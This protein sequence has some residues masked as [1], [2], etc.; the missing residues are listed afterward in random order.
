[1][2]GGSDDESEEEVKNNAS[3]NVENTPKV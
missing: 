3:E 2:K 1:L